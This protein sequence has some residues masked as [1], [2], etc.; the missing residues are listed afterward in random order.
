MKKYFLFSLVFVA[1]M[2]ASGALFAGQRS[3]IGDWSVTFQGYV[4]NETIGTSYAQVKAVFHITNQT[5]RSFA[6]TVEI[7]GDSKTYAL[8][9]DIKNDNI[10]MILGGNTFVRGSA[11]AVRLKLIMETQR[12]SSDDTQGVL[13]GTASK[14]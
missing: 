6:G 9:G 7:E 2:L 12:M 11:S 1:V 13:A 8:T 10:T 14:I 5:G 4:G 3:L